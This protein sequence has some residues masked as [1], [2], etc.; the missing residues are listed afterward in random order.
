MLSEGAERDRSMIPQAD[1]ARRLNRYRSAIDQAVRRVFDSGCLLLGPATAAFETE[2]AEYLGARYAIAV[3]SGFAA[4]TIA[5]SAL[6]IGEGDEVIVPSLTAPATGGAIKRIGARPVFVDVNPATRTIDPEAAAAAIGPRTAAIV[7]VHLHGT[8]AAMP[9]IL[10]LASRHGLH[11]IEDCAQAHGATIGG[12]K[13]GTL[14]IAAAFSFYPTKNLGAGG[15]AGAIVTSDPGM[16]ER[17]RRI[18][19]HGLDEHGVATTLGET[20]RMD[21]VQAAI[22][23]VLLPHLDQANAQRRELAAGYRRRLVELPV[24]LPPEDENAVYHQFAILVDQRDNVMRRMAAGGVQTGVH[25]KRGLHLQPAFSRMESALPVTERLCERL[26]SLS[27]QPEVAS[28]RVDEVVECLR[29]SIA[30]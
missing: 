4:L 5:L 16:A 2:F 7:P 8:A 3:S 26:L 1:P 30:A 11:V 29:R 25:Y 14:G 21:E 15:D 27:I 10:A 18:R 22:L 13:L 23:R 17:A 6:A 19:S 28:G 24:G 9:E 20:G 12:K